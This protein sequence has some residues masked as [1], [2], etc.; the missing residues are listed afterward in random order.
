MYFKWV[1]CLLLRQFSSKVG[2][3]LYDSYLSDDTNYFNLCLY[4]MAAVLFKYSKKMKKMSFEDMMEFYQ[5]IPTRE[6][7]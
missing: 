3:R 2:L 4:I 7:K 1:A 6:W 5:K